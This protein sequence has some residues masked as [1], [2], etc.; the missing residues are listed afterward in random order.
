MNSN[1]N[2]TLSTVHLPSSLSTSI[3][4]KA[5][6]AEPDIGATITEALARAEEFFKSL[7]ALA[8]LLPNMQASHPRTAAF[9]RAHKTIPLTFLYTTLAVVEQT[10]ALQQLAK[11]DVVQA[12]A[13]L[14]IMEAFRP[15]LDRMEA[16]AD[17]VRFTLDSRRSDLTDDSLQ[18]YE[19][20]KALARKTEGADEVAK[21][22]NLKRDM[23]R[24]Q[25]KETRQKKASLKVVR[26]LEAAKA[27]IAAHAHEALS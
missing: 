22:A 15:V 13:T 1:D 27:Y 9:V 18:A 3:D 10:P 4:N 12:R 11:F 20:I 14:Q 26:K 7:D 24:K 6:A 19:I 21:A 17:K 16:F 23:G 8:A 25:T 2:D 5:T